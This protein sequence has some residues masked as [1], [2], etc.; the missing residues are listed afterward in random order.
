MPTSILIACKSLRDG[1][2]RLSACLGPAARHDL[3]RRLLERTLRCALDVLPAS[4]VR[5]VTAD[6][7]ATAIAQ[8][9]AISAIA[10]PGLGLNA[11]LEQARD[12]LLAEEPPSGPDM[13]I[14]PIDLPFV[15]PQ[16]IAEVLARAGDC[17][18]APDHAGTGTNLLFLRSAAPRTVPFAFGAGSYAAHL[19]LAQSRALAVVTFRDRRLAFDLDDPTDYESW[20]TG[21]RFAGPCVGA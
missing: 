6:P 13:L 11:A 3:S 19:S 9:H 1:K 17:G 4:Q 16:C 8:Q 21:V 18:I 14:L 15:T 2:S 7:E 12:H 20:R 5:I 10:D